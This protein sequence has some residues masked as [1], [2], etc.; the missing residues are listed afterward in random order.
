MILKWSKEGE[1]TW[2]SRLYKVHVAPTGWF[3]FA[4]WIVSILHGKQSR[5]CRK[6]SCGRLQCKGA[7][8]GPRNNHPHHCTTSSN[9]PLIKGSMLSCLYQILI[10]TP[11]SCSLQFNIVHFGEPEQLQCLKT[12]EYII[13]D[14]LAHQMLN[15]KIYYTKKQMLLTWTRHHQTWLVKLEPGNIRWYTVTFKRYENLISCQ[16]FTTAMTHILPKSSWWF[17]IF[18]G[19]GKGTNVNNF[20][21]L[22]LIKS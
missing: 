3:S 17:D 6:T 18:L 20:I 21:E 22:H 15:P 4:L 5:K 7:P 10:P 9:D 11:E 12:Q 8:C 16:P 13:L 2:N 14:T 19:K 1:S